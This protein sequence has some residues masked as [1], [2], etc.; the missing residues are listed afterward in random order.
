MATYI[1]L[2]KSC[3]LKNWALWRYARD[4]AI[5]FFETGYFGAYFYYL[6]SDVFT[7]DVGVVFHHEA[8]ISLVEKVLPTCM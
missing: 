6:P 3:V 1:V 7:E 4:Y 2:S 5:A 8:Y